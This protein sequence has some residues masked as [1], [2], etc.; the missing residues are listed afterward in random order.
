MCCGVRNDVGNSSHF[1][2][3][4]LDDVGDSC[5]ELMKKI[6]IFLCISAELSESYHMISHIVPTIFVCAQF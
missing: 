1:T 4:F 5:R 6:T 3:C 2:L